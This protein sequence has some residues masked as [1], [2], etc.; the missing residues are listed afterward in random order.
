[1]PMCTNAAMDFRVHVVGHI[2]KKNTVDSSCLLGY[3]R[4]SLPALIP[5][6]HAVSRETA[7]RP[8]RS[9]SRP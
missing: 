8:G 5:R 3:S 4:F 2:C 7:S 6:Y 9:R 1:M